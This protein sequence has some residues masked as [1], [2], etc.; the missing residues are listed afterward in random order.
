M[1]RLIDLWI[2]TAVAYF[3]VGVIMGTVMGATHN[4]TLR[5]VHVHVNLLGWVSM[6]LIGLIHQHFAMTL[7]LKLARV[8]FWVYQAAVPVMLVAL[9][10]VLMGNTAFEPVL[11]AASVA[12]TLS[13]LMLAF[14]VGWR[15]AQA[16]GV[17]GAATRG[18]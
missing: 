10:Q 7:N 17:S 11:G 1:K 8:Q 9:S 18:A 3:V 16:P 12:V 15:R 5:P 2:L 6:V 13:V 14:N 4:F